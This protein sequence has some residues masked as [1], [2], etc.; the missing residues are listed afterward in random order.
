MDPREAVNVLETFDAMLRGIIDSLD[1]DGTLLLIT[2]DHGNIEDLTTKT[3]T[4]QPRA[5]HTVRRGSERHLRGRFGPGADLTAVTPSL[6]ELYRRRAVRTIMPGGMSQGAKPDDAC[7]LPAGPCTPSCPRIQTRPL[8]C[9]GDIHR[10]ACP[11]PPH[12][13]VVPLPA[14]LWLLTWASA[15]ERRMSRGAALAHCRVPHPLVRCAQIRRRRTGSPITPRSTL[16]EDRARDR[17]SD[18]PP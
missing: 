1:A 17:D 7:P 14:A 8:F 2:S 9:R 15:R 12:A 16:R 11:L 3:H 10:C 5:A 6:L 4:L 18:N 13:W